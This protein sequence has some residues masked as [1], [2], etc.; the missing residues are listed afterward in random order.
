MYIFIIYSSSTTALW[1]TVKQSCN[2]FLDKCWFRND[3]MRKI[4]SNLWFYASHRQQEP[5]P[6]REM[7][8]MLMRN[9][10]ST[11]NIFT[12]SKKRPFV[13]KKVD[14]SISF[15]SLHS[16]GYR[17][18][19]ASSFSLS[20][21]TWNVFV[22]CLSKSCRRCRPVNHLRLSPWPWRL[23]LFGND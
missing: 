14:I 3:G 19:F 4:L 16:M 8:L 23:S 17:K 21:S 1:S 22:S 13:D 9:L 6:S 7:K 12:T 18:Q 11:K 2:C 5:T 20:K 10:V 15:H